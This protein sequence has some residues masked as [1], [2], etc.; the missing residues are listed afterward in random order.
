VLG[1]DVDEITWGDEYQGL[2]H[3]FECGRHAQERVMLRVWPVGDN[4]Q[5]QTHEGGLP[6]DYMDLFAPAE[7]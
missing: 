4:R 5:P 6:P 3:C 7:F 2:V 1:F